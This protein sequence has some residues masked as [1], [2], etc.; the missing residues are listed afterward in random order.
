MKVLKFG[1]TSLGSAERMKSVLAIVENQL[2]TSNDGKIL[3]VLSAVAG[4]TD[5]LENIA[6]HVEKSKCQLAI[7]QVQE[8]KSFYLDYTNKLFNNI[9][10]T[11]KS[12]LFIG[13]ILDSI[14]SKIESKINTNLSRPLNN[15]FKRSFNSNDLLTRADILSVGELISTQLFHFLLEEFSCSNTRLNSLD[16]LKTDEL[17]VP[18]LIMLKKSLSQKIES[19]T[20]INIFV[21]QGF[22]CRNNQGEM[23]NLKRGGSDYSASLF[24]EAIGSEELQIWT[25]IDGMHNN[26]PRY[27]N[28]TKTIRNISFDE[29][30]ELAYFG[31]KI[32]HPS[33]I[34]PAR[35][36]NIP[37]RLLNTLQPEALGTLISKISERKLVKAVA[38][39]DGITAIK[40]RSSEMLEAQGF[41]RKI[42]EV[43]EDN[44]TSIDMIATSEVA[45]SVTID[46]VD[47]LSSIIEELSLFSQVDVDSELS[48]IC[49]VGEHLIENH[50][51]VSQVT[52]SLKTIPVRMISYGG[53]PHNISLLVPSENKVKALNLLQ[54][55]L[56]SDI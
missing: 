6:D 27:V 9:L 35:K 43:F 15:S 19:K 26:D 55:G 8:L 42:F 14:T 41:L 11:K 12:D 29:A 31:A 51:V 36:N 3:V 16:F 2:L 30:A 25:D 1:G 10:N 54:K 22:I 37:V 13:E 47:Y 53:S 21:A 7:K 39:K 17:G 24:A 34:K 5:Q 4:T 32:L 20:E 40:I 18:D 45:V 48:I 50:D 46:N 44:K 23:S 28:G 33:S 52:H 56:F 38:A 49:V